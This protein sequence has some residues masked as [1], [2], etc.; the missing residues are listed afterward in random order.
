MAGR[1]G[2]YLIGSV[3]AVSYRVVPQPGAQNLRL[4]ANLA[5]RPDLNVITLEIQRPIGDGV[6][7]LHL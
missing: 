1:S 7:G 5:A 3:L 2:G 6:V 4:C